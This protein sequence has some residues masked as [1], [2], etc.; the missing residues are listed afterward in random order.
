MSVPTQQDIDAIVVAHLSYGTTDNSLRRSWL[1]ATVLHYIF[2]DQGR[3]EVLAEA[4]AMKRDC[5]GILARWG[6]SPS[7]Y[8]SSQSWPLWDIAKQDHYYHLQRSGF[9][10]A[11][12]D[13]AYQPAPWRN[14]RQDIVDRHIGWEVYMAYWDPGLGPTPDTTRHKFGT[15]PRLDELLKTK[16]RPG[17]MLSHGLQSK[18]FTELGMLVRTLR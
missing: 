5:L 6:I 4:D 8:A 10:L 12:A 9:P 3:D 2:E 7:Q 16:P 11:A 17:R 13:E 15:N 14:K 18:E 1:Y